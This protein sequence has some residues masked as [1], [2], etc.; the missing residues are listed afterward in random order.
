MCTVCLAQEEPI[1]L[2]D[3]INS[4]Y[5]ERVPLISLDGKVLYF[6]RK[7]HPQN[8]GEND[9]DDIW[10]SYLDEDSQTWTKAVNVGSP[11]NNDEHNFVVSVNTSAD[12]MYLANDYNTNVKDAI[13]YT[14]R[15]GRKWAQPKRLDIPDYKN[16]SPFVSYHVSK[17]EKYLLIAAEQNKTVGGRDFYVSFK[18]K[19]GWSSPL[20]LGE[21]INSK[22]EENS[23]FLAADNKTVYFSSNGRQ[24]Q[25]GYDL[26]MSRRLDE[27]WTK[28]STPKNLGNQINTHLDDLSISI[29]ASGDYVY[30][31]RGPIENT[32]IFK[33]K[34]PQA[35]KP[36]PVTF[37]QAQLVDAV[38]QK[39]VN[40][41]IYFESLS[42]QSEESKNTKGKQANYIVQQNEDLGI[43]AQVPGYLPTSDFYAFQE[44]RYESVDGDNEVYYQNTEVQILQDKL[45]DLQREL[46]KLTD[47]KEYNSKRKNNKKEVKSRKNSANKKTKTF[48]DVN[49]KEEE[50]S[51]LQ[52]KYEQHFQEETEPLRKEEIEAKESD[53][54]ALK[55]SREKYAQYY[56]GGESANENSKSKKPSSLEIKSFSRSVEKA[57]YTEYYLSIVREVKKSENI[58]L[59]NKDIAGLESKVKADLSQYWISRLL[60]ELESKHNNKLK[61]EIK[62]Q[63]KRDMKEEFASVVRT[64]ITIIIKQQKEKDIETN[65]N[66]QLAEKPKKKSNYQKNSKSENK[67][68]AFQQVDKQLQLV[69][70]AKGAILRLNNIFFDI[71][72][73]SLKPQSNLELKRI[74]NFMKENPQ[75]QMEIS[76]HTNGWCSP[77]FA[78]ALSEDRAASIYQHLI[79]KGISEDKLTYKGYGKSD[80]IAS[81]TTVAGRKQNQRVELKIIDIIE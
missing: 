41:R 33:A 51:S 32:D 2:G 25:G 71:N 59:S 36:E 63:L 60:E 45:D 15:M 17:D 28:W 72:E 75:L 76:G 61:K 35:L 24:G 54:D 70:I 43:Y 9:K 48:K 22:D 69:P 37:I 29:P 80:P 44:E 26:Y 27:S 30:L 74:F 64:E 50:L 4:S 40:G 53:S 52:S 31:A 6:A 8:M 23:I 49:E 38:T 21:D 73:A 3:V 42:D 66:K 18:T 13:S 5:A 39:N 1:R 62:E 67:E 16:K 19:N 65:I 7:V 58:H 14:T 79:D 46:K 11:L 20:N 12:A 56:G 55:A 34:L 57:L 10:I 77:E 47:K 68:L 78:A 81:N